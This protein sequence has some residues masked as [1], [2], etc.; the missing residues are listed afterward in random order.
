MS[1]DAFDSLK[2]DDRS[3]HAYLLGSLD[4]EQLLTL[5]RALVYQVAGQ[6]RSSAL[7]LCEHPPIVTVGRHGCPAHLRF[8]P[9][10]LAA[11]G[12]R[13]RWVN[14]GGGCVLHVPGQLAIYPIVALDEQGVGLEAYL[15]RLHDLAIAVLDDFG[16]RAGRCLGRSG[17]WVGDRP[18]AEVGV[19][20][21]HWVAHFGVYL[22][23]YPD[24]ALFRHV[25]V[26][27]R[28]SGPMTSLE[29]ERRGPLRPALVRERLLEHF[30]AAFGC[31]RTALSFSH[32]VVQRDLSGVAAHS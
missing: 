13:V 5:Q 32:P 29:R 4:F 14:R 17:V 7:V 12:W 19:A 25:Q 24:L 11:R 2:A 10:E 9:A 6:R 3:L 31:E 23:V 16:V 18:I 21:R 22:N 27:G 8:E 30:A 1:F 28:G 15:D 20:V 26:G